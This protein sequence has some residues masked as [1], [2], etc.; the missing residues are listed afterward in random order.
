MKKTLNILLIITSLFGYTEWGQN[1][2]AFIFE[3]EYEVVSNFTSNPGT[4][5][6]PL[7]VL[8]FFGQLVIVFTLFQKEPNRILTFIGLGCLSTILIM[9]FIAGVFATNSK[10]IIST[11]PFIL[12]ALYTLRHYWKKKSVV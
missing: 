10:M 8:P 5:T 1:K 3:M 2:H 12:V 4:F 6:H 9:F 11:L 7:V